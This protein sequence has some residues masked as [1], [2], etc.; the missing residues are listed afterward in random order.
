MR[1]TRREFIKLGAAISA[2]TFMV[3]A[4][5]KSED[6]LHS[7]EA[8]EAKDPGLELRRYPPY[9]KWQE[10]EEL[11][12]RYPAE[13]RK[14]KFWVGFAST[15]GFCE[16]A[17]AYIAW[18]DKETHRLT[19]VMSPYTNFEKPNPNF[20][21][22]NAGL[23][24]KGM[25]IPEAAYSPERI[26]FPLK[27]APGSK[28]GEGKWVRITWDEAIEM[29]AEQLSKTLYAWWVEGDE[30]GGKTS[31]FAE[32]RPLEDGWFHAGGWVWNWLNSSG[33]QSHTNICSSGARLGNALWSG[34]DRNSPDYANAKTI[35]FHGKGLLGD[36]GHYLMAHAPRVMHARLNGAKVIAIR[37]KFYHTDMLSDFRP[38]PPWPGTEAGFFLA[39][40]HVLVN[41]LDGA[42]W[43]FIRRW[44]N[45]D[46]LMRDTELLD[47]LLAK[48]FIKTKPKGNTFEDFKTFLKEYLSNWTPEWAEEACRVKAEDVRELARLIKQAGKAFS[49]HQWRAAPTG[50]LG[51]FMAARCAYLLLALVGAVGEKGGTGLAG[52]H[53]FVPA[54][55]GWKG[56][57]A[58]KEGVTAL[59][60]ITIWNEYWMPP[61]WSAFGHYDPTQNTP[62]IMYDEEWKKR[63]R[64]KGA[65]IPDK[66]YLFAF[67]VV[68]FASSYTLAPL[69]IRLL[70]DET[71]IELVVQWTPFWNETAYF[72]DLVLPEG[73]FH[74]R[75]ETH[76]EPTYPGQWTH[77]RHPV[78]D[79]YLRDTQGWQPKNKNRAGLEAHIKVGLGEIWGY[80][81]M[82]LEVF[83]RAAQKVE[84]RA[85]EKGVPEEK[86]KEVVARRKLIEAPEGGR[87]L[88]IEEWYE[89]YMRDF[90]KWVE[91]AKNAGFTS[92]LE[93]TRRFG[94]FENASDVYKDKTYESVVKPEAVARVDEKTH[95]A[96]DEKGSV[97]GVEVD[98]KVYVG[99]PTPTR[100][101]EF[102]STAL[103]DW[104]LGEY[105]LPI[106]PRTIKEHE[107]FPLI[108]S[109]IHFK[110]IK[111]PSEGGDEFA[112]LANNR[113]L[114][115]SENS[116]TEYALY[117]FELEP[118][119]YLW[120]NARDAAKLGLK[121]GDLVR[122]TIVETLLNDLEISYF[123]TRVW[124]T[125]R[126]MPGTVVFF[127]GRFRWKPS[128]W[129]SK[130]EIDYE[131]RKVNIAPSSTF[132][133]TYDIKVDGKDLMQAGTGPWK[134]VRYIA[135]KQPEPSSTADRWFSSERS[136]QV[137]W[138]ETGVNV[139][140]AI[141]IRPDPISGSQLWACKVRVEKAH[142][143]DK[144]GDIYLNVEAAEKVWK[145]YRDMA[146]N[147]IQVGAGKVIPGNKGLR[148]PLFFAS[149][150]GGKPSAGAYKWPY[151]WTPKE[152]GLPT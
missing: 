56:S 73:F 4:F 28:R 71:K 130:I 99:F 148:R 96:Y 65:K 52:W 120:M 116:R 27:R 75:W 33:A 3:P 16:A 18:I 91:A 61:E 10:W 92:V 62:F 124:A 119:S 41:E 138:R 110:Y 74:E 114:F 133:A 136:E 128:W 78:F 21:N 108:V 13:T 98:G 9:E 134:E 25:G 47:W 97:I 143:G 46:W 79:L 127:P 131:G 149:G 117:N 109:Q 30:A 45:W 54:V 83:W 142:P 141:P 53:K 22:N 29:M 82:L 94:F 85:R 112:Y 140:A 118:A 36:T 66:W 31:F 76:S 70:S 107:L 59:P 43:E 63:W 104:G 57:L 87:P 19:K 145:H 2:T 111:T 100:K 67:R 69:W 7:A 8:A 150:V 90:P 11:H 80:Q 26:P 17:C 123:V 24:V 72:C 81:E 37:D 147:L 135:I 40:A 89:A 23:C 48:G 14:R 39:V 44:W 20:T 32:G 1:L 152:R 137:W 49:L 86:I 5:M 132:F 93:Y 125:E 103:R 115:Q 95:L 88:T 51:G 84:Q 129:P 106:Y 35:L 144:Y 12:P 146:Y 77:I 64:E 101:L 50:S 122:V 151:T 34:S 6:L 42:D 113:Y 55:R 139:N 121:S 15:C 126:A 60:P 38:Y 68:N 102:Y 58:A 105:A